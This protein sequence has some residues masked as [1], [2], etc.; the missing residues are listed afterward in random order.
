MAR[1]STMHFI[2]QVGFV[3][4]KFLLASAVIFSGMLAAQSYAVA[5]SIAIT[6]TIIDKGCDVVGGAQAMDLDL[7]MV[8]RTAF[9]GVVGATLGSAPLKISLANCPTGIGSVGVVFDGSAD[10]ENAD[11]LALQSAE[12]G[13]KGVGIAFYEYDSTTQIKLHHQ[14]VYNPLAEGQTDLVLNYVAKYMA[15]SKTVVGGKAD[16]VANFTLV[17]N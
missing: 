11:L 10:A 9:G 15:T 1:V 6:G 2:N 3:M 12:G 4:K 7:G 8:D 16:A 5:G 13:A 17:Y 14:S